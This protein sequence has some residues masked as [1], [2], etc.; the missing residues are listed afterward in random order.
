MCGQG[1]GAVCF[2][3]TLV[4]GHC[5]LRFSAKFDATLQLWLRSLQ[6]TALPVTNNVFQFD[7]LENYGA[8]LATPKVV[9]FDRSRRETSVTRRAHPTLQG[10]VCRENRLEKKQIMIQSDTPLKTTVFGSR[11]SSNE[12]LLR[13]IQQ[14]PSQP[15]SVGYT[16]PYLRVCRPFHTTGVNWKIT[17]TL[18]QSEPAKALSCSG[19]NSARGRTKPESVLKKKCHHEGD[20]PS[21]PVLALVTCC[22]NSLV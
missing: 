5:K 7:F 19:Q 18:T 14:E 10:L 16:L 20:P 2:R 6:G 9:S 12:G 4:R 8:I 1:I 13:K 21:E 22:T 11:C 15:C 3:F 17:M